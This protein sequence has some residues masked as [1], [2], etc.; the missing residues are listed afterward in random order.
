MAHTGLVLY[1]GRCDNYRHSGQCGFAF[2]ASYNSG[3]DIRGFLICWGAL[4]QES[5]STIA[6]GEVLMVC[7]SEPKFFGG[8]GGGYYIHHILQGKFLVSI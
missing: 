6:I 3:K 1:V 7:N 4:Q 8:N 5:H 2:L